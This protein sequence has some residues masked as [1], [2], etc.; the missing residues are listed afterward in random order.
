MSVQ[1]PA[2]LKGEDEH[3]TFSIRILKEH[4]EKLEKIAAESGRSRNFV[5]CKILENGVRSAVITGLKKTD[6]PEASAARAPKP[7]E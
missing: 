5:I 2:K 1:I 6:E 3:V 4:A 7:S